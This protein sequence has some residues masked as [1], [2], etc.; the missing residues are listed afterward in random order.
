[1]E[2][3]RRTPSASR[4]FFLAVMS[5]LL[6]VAVAASLTFALFVSDVQHNTVKIQSGEFDLEVYHTFL[7]G[8]RLSDGT[9]GGTKGKLIGFEDDKTQDG[10]TDGIKLTSAAENSKNNIFT[11]ADAVPGMYQTATFK[12]KN[13]GD[14]AFQCYLEICDLAKDG[15]KPTA[16][17]ALAEQVWIIVKDADGN[18]IDEPVP[19]S[20]DAIDTEGGA[21]IRFALGE[22]LPDSELK[23]ITVTALFVD[24]AVDYSTTHNITHGLAADA[25]NATSGGGLTFDITFIAEQSVDVTPAP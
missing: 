2:E 24:S 3:R 23:D 1:M 20:N 17:D 19:L 11:I 25:N 14:V 6:T 8:I 4:A 9:D 16:D 13:T 10:T 15:A 18:I 12:Y 22:L 7:A 21:G 5:M